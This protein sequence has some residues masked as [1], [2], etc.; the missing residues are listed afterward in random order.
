[1][2]WIWYVLFFSYK[3]GIIFIFIFILGV[4][5]NINKSTG[6]IFVTTPVAP[7]LLKHVN[8]FN[9]GNINLPYTFYT[10]GTQISKFVC[11]KQDNIFN[12]DVTRHYKVM[13]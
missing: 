3:K 4:V 6:D 10:K 2:C 12:E 9:L 11:V 1:M 8:Q 7:D 5:R 13:S